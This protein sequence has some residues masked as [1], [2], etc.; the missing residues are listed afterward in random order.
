M[1]F[2]KG[3]CFSIAASIIF[4]QRRSHGKTVETTVCR[5]VQTWWLLTAKKN[6]WVNVWIL[7]FK[8]EWW[9]Y[10]ISA[11]RNLSVTV[12]L[13]KQGLHKEI[14]WNDVDWIDWH[15]DQVDMEMGWWHS[16]D[17]KVNSFIILFIILLSIQHIL[18]CVPL[19]KDFFFGFQ[20]L[21][22]WRTQ[23]LPR[24]RRKLCTNQAL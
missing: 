19:L 21:G 12:F 24:Q 13:S 17:P 15:W 14:S 7:T 16:D 22:Q 8:K 3:G 18:C 4:H 6:M 11:D 2:N 20:L 10:C 1:I 5:K 9:I 23:Q